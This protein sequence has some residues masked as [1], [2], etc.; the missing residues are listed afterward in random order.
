MKVAIIGA[1]ASGLAC[2]VEAATRAKENKIKVDITV[3]E[4]RDKAGR[5]IL[6][7]GNGRCNLMNENEGDYFFD[8]NGFAAYALKKFNVCS[9]LDFFAKLGLFTRSDDEGRIYPLSNQA[10]SVLD[11]L[12][13]G[14]ER[15]GVKIICDCEIKE[16]KHNSKKFELNGSDS[17]DFIVL[18]CGGKAGVKSFNGYELLRQTGHSITSV[19]PSLTKIEI[20]DKKFSKQLKGIRQKGQ[21]ALCD[22]NGIICQ[23]KGELLFTDYGI[24]GIAVMQLSAYV[25]RSAKMNDLRV[26]ADFVSEL[27]YNQLLDAVT[28]FVKRNP[29]EKL[30]NLLSGFVAKKLG[31]AI[32]RGLGFDLSD[33][34]SSLDEKKIKSIVSK[35]KKYTFKI[36]GV[37]GF[38]DAQVTAGGAETKFFN[39]KTMESKKV[40]GL[41]CI[42]ELLDVDGLCGGYNLHWAWSSGRLCGQSII[43]ELLNRKG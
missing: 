11:A 25:V 29:T 30:Q 41:Y 14:C 34:F 3:F 21:F 24:S 20:T 31:E 9:N 35:L 5:K 8:K 16:I 37:K 19:Y 7:T 26:D 32:M 42:G 22:S 4:S 43:N 39:G 40:K 12:R 15:L 1:G 38:D 23:E 2:A 36:E 13:F 18:A 28:D 10:I 27:S 17:Y 33:T 6:A